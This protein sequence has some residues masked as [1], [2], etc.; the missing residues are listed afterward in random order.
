MY[1]CSDTENADFMSI[2]YPK[3]L[4]IVQFFEKMIVFFTRADQ[5]IDFKSVIRWKGNK[6]HFIADR[7][8]DDY[9]LQVINI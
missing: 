7:Y 1:L 2:Y 9:D 5:N 6:T 8:Y 4:Q 3:I